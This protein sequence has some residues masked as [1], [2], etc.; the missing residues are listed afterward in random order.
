MV[1]EAETVAASSINKLNKLGV[2]LGRR[3]A[4]HTTATT[5]PITRTHT[6]KSFDFSTHTRTQ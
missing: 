6:H 2:A 4:A 1:A 3:L 5:K